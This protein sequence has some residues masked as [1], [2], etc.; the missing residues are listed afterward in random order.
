MRR[1]ITFDLDGTLMQNPFA[2]AIFPEVEELVSMETGSACG[3]KEKLMAE[4]ERLMADG[5]IVDAYDWDAIVAGLLGELGVK[6]AVDIV[7]M[8]VR[9][10]I[11]PKIFLLDDTILPALERLK[12][13]GYSLAAVTNGY[14]KYQY[15]VMEALGLAARLDEIVTPDRSGYAKP[16][17]RMADALPSG[18]KIVLH[19]GDRLDHDVAFARSLGVPSALIHRR[20]PEELIPLSPKERANS[21]ALLPVLHSLAEKESGAPVQDI[22]PFVPT[23]AIRD[24]SE[25]AECL[26]DSEGS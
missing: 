9:H 25:L 4:H 19:V 10:S 23:Y 17:A 26:A 7:E 6:R 15:P 24:L 3:M 14:Y 2:G 11:A 16:D 1:W 13:E 18:D 22:A 8:V 12:R 5:R 20:L 21:T